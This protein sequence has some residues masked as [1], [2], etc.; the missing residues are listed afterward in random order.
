MHRRLI[1]LARRWRVPFGLTVLAGVLGGW[2]IIAQAYL[3]S[4]VISRVFVDHQALAQVSRFMGLLLAVI[5]G[6]GILVWVSESAA[7]RIAQ[8]FT[9]DLRGRLIRHILALGPAFS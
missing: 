8:R 4:A 1:S 7:G 3:V 5:L 2:L 6:R 9:M